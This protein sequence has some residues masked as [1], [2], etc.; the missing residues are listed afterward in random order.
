LQQHDIEEIQGA[1]H[2]LLERVLGSGYHQA[3]T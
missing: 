2:R 1:L 3:G